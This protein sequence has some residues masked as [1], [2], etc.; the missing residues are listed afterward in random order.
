MTR[1]SDH[2]RQLLNCSRHPDWGAVRYRMIPVNRILISSLRCCFDTSSDI[3]VSCWNQFV[4]SRLKNCI[5]AQMKA[6]SRG[7]KAPNFVQYIQ[8]VCRKKSKRNRLPVS[9]PFC[10]RWLYPIKQTSRAVKTVCQNQAIACLFLIR[11]IFGSRNNTSRHFA[12]LLQKIYPDGLKWSAK[13]DIM[14]C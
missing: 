6:F 10:P 8:A 3:I 14:R 2:E 9:A 12:H 4:N 13:C 1:S 11:W 5:P 7:L